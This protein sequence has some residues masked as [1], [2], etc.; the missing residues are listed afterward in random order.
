MH[1]TSSSPWYGQYFFGAKI[2]LL[3]IVFSKKGR[4]HCNIPFIYKKENLSKKIYIWVSFARCVFLA[5]G[6]SQT[7]RGLTCFLQVLMTS[8]HLLLNPLW[9]ACYGCSSK[10]N[11]KI[12]KINIAQYFPLC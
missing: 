12:I 9:D 7:I 11:N 5:I 3:Q 1:N 2:S 6:G 10:I 4:F 8:H